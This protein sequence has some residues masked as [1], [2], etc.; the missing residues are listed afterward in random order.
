MTVRLVDL[1]DEGRRH[2]HRR[3]HGRQEFRL[4]ADA[5][6]TVAAS[7]VAGTEGRASYKFDPVPVD[8]TAINNKDAAL[9]FAVSPRTG[10][11]LAATTRTEL[12]RHR[13]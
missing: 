6:I 8:A 9:A 13:A 3:D 7:G 2:R 10:G 12:S 1:R 4:L 11:C 5:W